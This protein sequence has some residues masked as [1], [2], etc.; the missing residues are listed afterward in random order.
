M[1]TLRVLPAVTMETHQ[2]NSPGDP[3]TNCHGALEWYLCNTMQCWK[4]SPIGDVAALGDWLQISPEGLLLGITGRR[5][6]STIFISES[7][8]VN[9]HTKGDLTLS[10]LNAPLP[11]SPYISVSGCAS[12]RLP[13]KRARRRS[14]DRNQL[15]AWSVTLRVLNDY[16]CR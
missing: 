8:N 14:I 16:I 12:L 7:P 3:S 9:L 4:V 15:Q 6:V 10:S 11:L 5:Y 13:F 2:K 1:R